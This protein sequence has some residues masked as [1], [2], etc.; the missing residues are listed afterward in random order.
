MPKKCQKIYQKNCIKITPKKNVG[1]ICQ[2]DLRIP[3][4]SGLRR[5]SCFF[6]VPHKDVRKTG[7]LWAKFCQDHVLLWGPIG[8]IDVFWA[9][10]LA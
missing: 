10:L 5:V 2:T 7:K 9:L 3:D 4:L 6:S 1:K 8:K